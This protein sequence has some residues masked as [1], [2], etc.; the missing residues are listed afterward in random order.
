MTMVIRHRA[1]AKVYSERFC[2]ELGN[3]SLKFDKLRSLAPLPRSFWNS[4]SAIFGPQ[5]TLCGPKMFDQ[6]K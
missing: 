1:V 4:Q 6:D 5:Q 2:R 3:F